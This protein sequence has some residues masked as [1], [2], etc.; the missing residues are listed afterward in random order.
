MRSN[1]FKFNIL[2]I[3]VVV[4]S[5]CLW[6]DDER[7]L[8]TNPNFYSL[9]FAKN[10][11]IPNLETA[12]FSLE[13]DDIL[14]DSIIVNLDSLPYLTR[15]D[16]VNPTFTFMSTAVSYLILKDSLGTGTDTIALTGKD[17]VD[18]TRVVSVLN[19]AEDQKANR[20]YPIKV[21][22]HQ[23]RPELFHWTRMNPAVY[24]HSGSIQKTVMFNN[25]FHF[26]AS[27]GF[28]NHLYTS[29]DGVNWTPV[30]LQGLPRDI[31]DLRSITIFNNALFYV[32]ENGE[33]YSSPDGSLWAKVPADAGTHTFVNL[34]FVLEGKLW[35]TV[36]NTISGNHYFAT[37]TGGVFWQVGEPIPGN[38]PVGDFAS[39][40]FA[41]RTN[42]PK[43]IVLGGY[44]AT[45]NLLR[46]A[47]SVQRNINNE[48]KWVDFSLE[49]TS[50]VSLAGASLVS[51]DDKLLLFGG[52]DAD[53]R[54]ID[55]FYMESID[56]G[57]TW[58]G[59]DTTYNVLYDEQLNVRYQPRSY[60]SV[61]YEPSSK[62]IFLF[63]GRTTQVYSDVWRGKL[64]RISFLR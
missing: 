16:S 22:V 43:A 17:T 58:R 42:K 19:Y 5:S 2:L 12:V 37:S 59:M 46:N 44:S 28:N 20:T 45:G 29:A 32:H 18:F 35:A 51:Y 53:D 9:K 15:I 1:W 30:V 36:R 57:L 25:R 10:D 40:A 38:F 54:V 34:L 26:F 11:S 23:V 14:K 33:L 62:S 47:W 56:E 49:N 4:M 39:L 3:A 64:N 60:Q 52:M 31:V 7:E 63:G 41:S 21:N 27:S 50:L 55:P 8:S 48:Y 24:S 6:E 61:V 13:Y